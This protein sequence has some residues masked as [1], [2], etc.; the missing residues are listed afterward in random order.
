MPSEPEWLEVPMRWL[1]R[2]LHRIKWR[3]IHNLTNGK[4]VLQ[5]RC[6]CYDWQQLRQCNPEDQVVVE[7]LI[8]MSYEDHLDAVGA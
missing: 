4:L 7:Q 6:T 5:A 2:L 8:L 1:N 3:E